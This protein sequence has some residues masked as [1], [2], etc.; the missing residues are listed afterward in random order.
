MGEW[1]DPK[2]DLVSEIK[3]YT[4]T[5]GKNKEYLIQTKLCGELFSKYSDEEANDVIDIMAVCLT[6]AQIEPESARH[7]MEV[8][9]ARFYNKTSGDERLMGMLDENLRNVYDSIEKK[10]KL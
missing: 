2:A 4:A 3:R 1:P 6:N 5:I 10:F 7:A 8:L 9:R